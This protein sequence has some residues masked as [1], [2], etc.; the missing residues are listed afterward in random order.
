MSDLPERQL[1]SIQSDF[2]CGNDSRCREGCECQCHRVTAE[3]AAVTAERDALRAELHSA[4]ID[5]RGH[6]FRESCPEPSDMSERD[7]EC[8]VCRRLQELD[9]AIAAS[10]GE[11]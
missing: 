4:L 8:P 11:S 1:A 5:C 3:L 6:L 2:C 10:K 7:P 9:A